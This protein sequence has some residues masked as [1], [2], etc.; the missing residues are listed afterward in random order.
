ML[1]IRRVT[2]P[3]TVQVGGTML[4]VNGLGLRT[5]FVVKFYVAGL[6]AQLSN[7]YSQSYS[8]HFGPKATRFVERQIDRHR[9]VVGQRFQR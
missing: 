7:Y 8:L 3:D 5:K 9:A 4:I 6:N 1:P 2:L